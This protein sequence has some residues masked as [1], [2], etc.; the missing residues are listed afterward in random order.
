MIQK[1]QQEVFSL[2]MILKINLMLVV[3]EIFVNQKV[4][5]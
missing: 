5:I 4:K 1:Y 3:K 2:V